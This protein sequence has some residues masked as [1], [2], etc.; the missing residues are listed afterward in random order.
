MTGYEQTSLGGEVWDK[1]GAKPVCSY[2]C[3]MDSGLEN[4]LGPRAGV[5]G[6]FEGDKSTSPNVLAI[7]C[8]TES[9]GS[10]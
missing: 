1:S 5:D 9:R 3:N 6:E 10:F 7:R 4:A 8:S 2:E